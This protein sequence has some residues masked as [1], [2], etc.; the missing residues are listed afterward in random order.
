MKVIV[1]LLLL[2]MF[3]FIFLKFFKYKKS[4]KKT[5]DIK[6]SKNNL[7]KWMKLTKQE[8][9]NLLKNES[10]SYFTKRKSL[11]EEIR[12]EYKSISKNDQKGL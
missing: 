7:Y 12:K 4:L 11:L 9:F 2:I 5:K 8:R 6:F 10:N 1:S 3:S